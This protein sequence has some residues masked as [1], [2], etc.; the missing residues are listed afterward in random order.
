MDDI[1]RI[2]ENQKE[3]QYLTY[4]ISRNRLGVIQ[5]KLATLEID[6]KYKFKDE[7]A[8][9]NKII[10]ILFELK[11]KEAWFLKRMEKKK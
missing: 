3:V 5:L 4:F 7:N 9:L 2:L 6:K 10:D 11:K 1:L 8:C